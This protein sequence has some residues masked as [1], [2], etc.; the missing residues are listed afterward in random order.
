[1]IEHNV[2]QG[3]AA[4][5]QLRARIPTASQFHRVI[6]PARLKA[7]EARWKYAVEIIAARV[8]NWQPESLD[9]IEHIEAGKNKEPMAVSQLEF[10]T[11][12][13]TRRVGFITTDDG[14]FGASPDRLTTPTGLTTI[15]VKCPTVPT[16]L[17]Y[18][19]LGHDDAYVCQVQG[20]LWVAEA[21]KAIFYSFHERMP[22]YLIE[23]VRDAAFIKSLADRLNQFHHEVAVLEDR[24]R[25]LGIYQAF[26]EMLPPAEIA[27]SSITSEAEASSELESWL[28]LE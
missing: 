21:D 6:T 1:M 18:L 5:H 15:E 11:G 2:D 7:S 13:Q 25:S 8:L 4:W 9:K 20:Q 24:A 12:L 19:L 14:R 27:A 22:P 26:Q 17:Q 28:E 10:T 3:S 23:T 16:H